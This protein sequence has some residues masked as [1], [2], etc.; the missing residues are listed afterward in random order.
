MEDQRKIIT[1]ELVK[2]GYT[3]FTIDDGIQITTTIKG[4]SLHL[5]CRL[6]AFF[7]YEI[8]SVFLA[9]EDW[10][11]LPSM[12]HKYTNGA[13]CTFDKSV[14]I[15]NFNEPVQL[16]VSTIEK[17]IDV[18]RNGIDGNNQVD[19]MDEFLAYWSTKKGRKAQFFVDDTS[20]CKDL[21]W[22]TDQSRSIISDSVEKAKKVF[23]SALGNEAD[24][25]LSGILIPINGNHSMAIPKTDLDFIR[26][27]KE[28]SDC[29]SRFN[30]FVQKHIN[31]KQFFVVASELNKDGEMLFGWCFKGPG[32]PNG[33]R[34]GHADL[35]LAFIRQKENGR[36]IAID[37]CSQERLFNR[38][39]DGHKIVI[40]NATIIGCGSIGSFAAEALLYYGTTHFSLV[41][42]D[43]LSYDNIA[44]HY[45]GYYW[46]GEPKV[47]AIK[48]EMQLHNPNT[49]YETF[50]GNALQYIEEQYESINNTDILIVSVGSTPVEHYI[51]KKINE[52]II[53]VPTL[54][55]WVEPYAFAGHGILINKPMD[56]YAELYNRKTME[57]RYAVL[58]KPEQYIKREAGC[59]SSYMPYSSFS[60]K[61]MIYRILESCINDYY[62]TG[63]NY[64]LTWCGRLSEAK[65]RGFN[66]NSNYVSMPDYSLEVERLD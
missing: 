62:R 64:R 48:T 12:P 59:Q 25:C 10:D 2:N 63:K 16:V 58:E 8:P 36:P 53:S 7:P 24:E 4:I 5:I 61:G 6:G 17:A 34:E 43:K 38:G 51:L 50:D 55:M 15:P 1:E 40:Q 19:Y 31:S 29:W 14:V 32:I 13:L 60:L 18:I 28:N 57:Y 66:I 45:A 56:V 65:I 27:I 22:I 46:V 42:C 44:R 21:F 35:A 41:D 54:I 9:E 52:G 33:F 49:V 39:G 3:A 47:R 11:L 37:N 30:S 23:L 26:L 20:V